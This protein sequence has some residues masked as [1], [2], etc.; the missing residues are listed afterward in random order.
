MSSVKTTT[1]KKTLEFNKT[2]AVLNRKL[3]SFYVVFGDVSVA[4]ASNLA[5]SVLKPDA[6]STSNLQEADQRWTPAPGLLF[7]AVRRQIFFRSGPVLPPPHPPGS[8]LLFLE[9]LLKNPPE[10]SQILVSHEYLSV[11]PV[12]DAQMYFI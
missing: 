5:S 2:L 6:P 11:S 8:S 4:A 7:Q 10:L 3:A 12:A 9:T 1:T